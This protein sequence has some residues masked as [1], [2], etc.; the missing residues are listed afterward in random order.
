MK[1]VE[2][3]MSPSCWG[4]AIS[5]TSPEQFEKPWTDESR[6]DVCGFKPRIPKVGDTL[7]AEFQR[8]WVTFEF[9]EVRPC[10]DPPDMFF[11]KVKLL[12]QVP[13]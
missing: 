1:S 6:F 8:S 9:A 4:N 12:K 7:L 11:A 10:G 2:Y 5:W 3:K 13:K